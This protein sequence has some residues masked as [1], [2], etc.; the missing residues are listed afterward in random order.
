MILKFFEGATVSMTALGSSGRMIDAW[1]AEQ[2]ETIEVG[3]AGVPATDRVP[4]VAAASVLAALAI[5][6][7]ALGPWAHV[8]VFDYSGVQGIGIAALCAGGVALIAS[9]MLVWHQRRA[10]A[11]L[12]A[13][14]AGVALVAAV[15][16]WVLVAIFSSSVDA[17]VA[18]LGRRGV[19]ESV[20]SVAE[21]SVGWGLV[22]TI[23]GALVLGAAA[24]LARAALAEEGAAHGGSGSGAPW[25][26]CDSYEAASDAWR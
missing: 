2:D 4:H 12:G 15:V 20:G 8:S 13:L 7:G 6:I 23:V 5:V 3:E 10:L 25:D 1:P 17:I 19:P 26:I 22:L 14:A 9:A 16:S 21:V 18:V 11:T 24:L